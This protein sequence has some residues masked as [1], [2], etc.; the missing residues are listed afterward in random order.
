MQPRGTA[1]VMTVTSP[2]TRRDQVTEAKSSRRRS[3]GIQAIVTVLVSALTLLA[4]LAGSAQGASTHPYVGTFPTG[5]KCAAE[6]IASDADGNYYVACTAKGLNNKFGSIRKFGP[7]GNPVPWGG[8]GSHISGNELTENPVSSRG[9]GGEWGYVNMSD[10]DTSNSI[11]RGYLYVFD[12]WGTGS[13]DVFDP[14]G[15]YVTTL[16]SEWANGSPSGV[17]IDDKGYVYLVYESFWGGHIT[18][19][20][21]V[22]YNELERIQPSREESPQY[23]PCCGRIRPDT[24]GGVW[25]GWGGAFFDINSVAKYEEYEFTTNTHIKYGE[26]QSIVVSHQSPYLNEKFEIEGFPNFQCPEFQNK[27]SFSGGVCALESK[28]YDVDFS[29]NDLYSNT[30]NNVV[31]YSQ[32]VPGNPVHQDG[33][34]FGSGLVHSGSSPFGGSSESRGISV[35]RQGNV[36][37][38]QGEEVVKWARGATL[39]N[40][41]TKPVA[42]ANIGHTTA[43]LPGVVDPDGGGEVTGCS[44]VYGTTPSY[45]QGPVNCK[46]AP[47]YPEGSAKEVT[48]ELT[49][50]TVGQIYH[51]RLGAGNANGFN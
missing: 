17:G 35:D 5:P 49:G 29:N 21:P 36:F 2:E 10:V 50:L 26:R 13:V 28:G 31:P 23:G 16:G 20:D 3:T 48:V 22:S 39:P 32:G 51:Y 47:P 9:G 30:G 40:P 19:F 43:L 7:N 1:E 24:D 8:S 11:R 34:D 37:V 14:T 18:K 12:Y 6:D 25:V 41:T 44:M 33:P 46:E 45:G 38:A 42:V 15:E 4:I 27:P